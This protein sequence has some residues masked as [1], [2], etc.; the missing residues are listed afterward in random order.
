MDAQGSGVDRG[1]G[2]PHS[3]LWLAP[4]LAPGSFAELS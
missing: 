3:G 4:A 2:A 1:H